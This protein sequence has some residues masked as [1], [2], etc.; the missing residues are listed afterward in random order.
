MQIKGAERLNRRTHDVVGLR[1]EIEIDNDVD[2]RWLRLM[3]AG[4][5][6]NMSQ[7]TAEK[8]TGAA[9]AAVFVQFLDNARNQ[10]DKVIDNNID[11]MP[12]LGAAKM[13]NSAFIRPDLDDSEAP[14]DIGLGRMDE[15]LGDEAGLPPGLL[16]AI[17][18]MGGDVVRLDANTDLDKLFSGAK[19]VLKDMSDQEAENIVSLCNRMV[20]MVMLMKAMG[21]DPQ[22]IKDHCSADPR[23][24]DVVAKIRSDNSNPRVPQRVREAAERMFTTFGL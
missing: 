15:G 2:A 21:I 9:N 18:E 12:K 24:M 7:Q 23:V 13:F 3:L 20:G 17:R 19:P 5:A 8:L 1:I 22:K 16:R 11:S 6:F 14:L 4:A 10:I